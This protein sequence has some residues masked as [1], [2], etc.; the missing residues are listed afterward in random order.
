MSKDE[1]KFVYDDTPLKDED[2]LL[3]GFY[4]QV[5]SYG[6]EVYLTQ[7]GMPNEGVVDYSF[8]EIYDQAVRMAAH[9]KGNVTEG[10]KIAIISKNC[11]HFF[12]CELAIWMS[13]CTTVAL[14]PNQSAGATK[15]VLEHS[16]PQL[17]F[18]GKLDDVAWTELKTGIPSALPTITFPLSP[19]VEGAK[20]W[21]DVVK[22]TDPICESVKDAPTRLAD[23]DA[24]IVY[25]SGSTGQPKGV[26]HTFHSL[27]APAKGIGNFLSA[28]RKDRVLSYLPIAH[29]MDRLLSEFLSFRTGMRVYFAES[30][31]TFKDDLTRCRPTLFVSV[32]RL[33]LKFQAGVHSKFSP[34]TLGRLLAIPL[35]STIIKRKILKVL[36]LDS[37]RFAGSGSAPI[38][39]EIL[40]WYRKLGLEL[41]EGYG[42]SENFCYSHSSYPGKAKA[43][44]IG[45]PFP[46]TECKLSEE[47]EILVKSPGM[48]KGYFKEPDMTAE[49]VTEDG[50]LKTGDKGFIDEDG[51]LKIIGRVKEIFKT[52]KGKYVAPAPIENIIN[53]DPNVEFSL[54]GGLGQV[55]PMVVVQLAEHIRVDDST[56]SKITA[57]FEELFKKVNGSVEEHERIAFI[58]VTKETWTIEKEL[59]TPTMKLK[60]GAIEKL[61][62]DNL[63]S[64]YS[65]KEKVIWEE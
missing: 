37:V 58:A 8:N 13:G 26:L 19:E 54:C 62:A 10:S 7:P 29:V 41:L 28:T 38:P 50:F 55:K 20:K 5:S 32:P 51:C 39:P 61:Y 24:I 59:L 21:E 42:M 65:K 52:S 36:G 60:R 34:K 16:E 44:F 43:G 14:F 25:T 2:L 45:Q 30:L 4:Q 31:S 17:L 40:G 9:I 63:D 35:I 56:K 47:S 3:Q 64:W 22:D 11:A 57:E 48:M 33:W 53:N 12:A 23:D 6:D 15:Y 27:S 1:N 18:I 46:G 49:V